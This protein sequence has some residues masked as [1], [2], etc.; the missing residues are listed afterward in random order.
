MTP[1]LRLVIPSP[2]RAPFS[3]R[4]SGRPGAARAAATA[5]PTTPPP[6]ITVS[7]RSW[8]DGGGARSDG[9]AV[10]RRSLHRSGGGL[11]CREVTLDQR[12]REAGRVLHRLEAEAAAHEVDAAGALQGIQLVVEAVLQR[13]RA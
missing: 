7:A 8:A 6:M 11:H 5:V 2:S 1:L 3:S 10:T 4:S 13:A 9:E 12:P